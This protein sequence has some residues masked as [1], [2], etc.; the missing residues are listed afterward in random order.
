MK[1]L[2]K[3]LQSAV[4]TLNTLAGKI[5]AISKKLEGTEK[6]KPAPAKKSSAKKTRKPAASK[7][8]KKSTPKKAVAPT[9]SET[10]FET[11]GLSQKGINIAALIEKTGFNK[12][13]LQNIVFK[14]RKQGKVKSAARGLYEKA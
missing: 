10:V 7:T 4:K 8:V 9:A 1:Q 3:Q 12:K 2:Q 11:I 6:A 5:E 13:K 14:L